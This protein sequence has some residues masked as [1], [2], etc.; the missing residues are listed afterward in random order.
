MDMAPFEKILSQITWPVKML[1]FSFAG[2]PL[3][4]KDI[5]KMIALAWRRKRI[6]SGIETNGMLLKNFK[7]EVF[8]SGLKRISVALDGLDQET[9]VRY[10]VGADFNQ[11]FSALKDICEIKRKNKDKGPEIVLQFLV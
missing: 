6:A 3:M 11:I 1:S 8:D 7:N 5:F 2:E 9:L 10:R 4:N